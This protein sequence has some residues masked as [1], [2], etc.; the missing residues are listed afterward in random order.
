MKPPTTTPPQAQEILRF[1]FSEET[2][3]RWFNATAEFDQALGERFLPVFEQA[4][5]GGLREWGD[6]PQGAL[7]LVIVLDQF[8]LN[9]FRHEARSFGTEAAARE[10]SAAAIARDFDQSLDPQGKTF[11]YLPFMHSENLDD[12]HR[13]VALFKAA[14][15]QDNLRFA[16]HHRDIVQRFGRF[17]HRN[18]ILGREST[19][20][21][22]AWL[23]SPQ[24]FNP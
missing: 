7:A 10:V 1:W 23:N 6:T 22:I 15:L 17:P 19:R 2:K 12:Q 5:A 3:V 24:G 9:L 13:S 11:L 21:E 4:E 18:R 20:E 14:G 16:R 8:P